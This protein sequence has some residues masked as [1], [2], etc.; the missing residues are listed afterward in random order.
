M[1]EISVTLND[2]SSSSCLALVSRIAVRKRPGE[3]PVS[4]RKTRE[5]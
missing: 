3:V 1:Y 2:V 5:K 4:V